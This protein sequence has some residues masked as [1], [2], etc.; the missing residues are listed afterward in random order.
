[1][2]RGKFMYKIYNSK[3]SPSLVHFFLSLNDVDIVYSVPSSVIVSLDKRDY[4]ELQRTYIIICTYMC[5]T[6]Y[7]H[8]MYIIYT[9]IYVYVL[10]TY[11]RICVY[12]FIIL[13]T[14]LYELQHIQLYMYKHTL[15]LINNEP[16]KTFL[17]CKTSHTL[18]LLQ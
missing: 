3:T 12:V 14:K 13:C 2:T 10:Y 5:I 11:T 9:Y 15:T 7:V 1:M 18:L 17:K 4:Y 6:L 16:L 8:I